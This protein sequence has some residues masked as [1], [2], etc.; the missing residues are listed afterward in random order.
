MKYI[1]TL[2]LGLFL[3]FCGHQPSTL[4]DVRQGGALKVVTWSNPTTYYQGPWGP[5]GLEF[6]LAKR[7]AR[8]LGV[9]LQV[10]QAESPQRVIPD[11]LAGRGH[12]AAARLMVTPRRKGLVRFGPVYDRIQQHV[13]YRR[14]E[15]R[16][17]SLEDLQGRH[18]EVVTPSPEARLLR[19]LLPRYPGLS[20]QENE[21]ADQAELLA[22]VWER[23][24]DV[25]IANEDE[26]ALARRFHP[27]L[28]SAFEVGEPTPVAW[29]FPPG[30]DDSLYLA[31]IRFFNAL[32]RRGE[33]ERL[34]HRHLGHTERVSILGN[35]KLVVRMHKRLPPLLGHFRDAARETGIDW[36]LL[37][38]IGYQESHWREHAVS[39]TG[40]RGIMML[41]MAAAEDLG[42][43]DRRDP[44]QSILG[45]ARYLVKM[46]EKVPERIGEP[47]RTWLALAGYNVGWGHLEDARRLTQ[48][49]GGNPD[50]WV[51]VR[52]HLPLLA[53]EKWH[54]RTR[55]GYARGWEP[56]KYVGNI[57]RYYD[58]L[59][60]LDSR[61]EVPA[62][63]GTTEAQAPESPVPETPGPR[64]ES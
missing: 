47:D 49:L 64:T 52:E 36:R 50:H 4:D 53:E 15:P 45:G 1:T 10:V 19:E 59:V 20:W 34:V 9:K 38:A 60:W 32:Q 22:L 23:V 30:S 62:A 8:E 54:S 13:V 51:D 43:E 5:T 48:S 63:A 21:S 39:P 26:L 44:R 55:Y 11:L 61:G 31:A 28:R 46:K 42:I 3:T 27:E 16:P 25:T 57:R 29:A 40:V 41:T 37:A 14:G 17:R 18:L 33:L 7:F 12:L 24:V 56:V 35:R 58:L 6:D 2:F